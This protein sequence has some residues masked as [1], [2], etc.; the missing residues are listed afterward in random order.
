[1]GYNGRFRVRK[2]DPPVGSFASFGYY[3][4]DCQWRYSTE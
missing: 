3:E 2:D 1:M 4:N